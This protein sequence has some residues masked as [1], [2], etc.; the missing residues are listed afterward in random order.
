MQEVFLWTTCAFAFTEASN[1]RD[2]S[3]GEDLQIRASV[4][5]LS[6]LYS[7]YSRRD[8]KN[9]TK[10]TSA[11][12]CDRE[13]LK[14]AS[15]AHD[16]TTRQHIPPGAFQVGQLWSQELVE[17]RRKGGRMKRVITAITA[18]FLLAT[19]PTPAQG[20]ET[21]QAEVRTDVRSFHL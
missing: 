9:D 2:L 6:T 13:G 21:L 3:A 12:R 17:A 7:E 11:G 16:S 4:F 1:P 18:A 20:P 8:R 15:R 5:A 19:I 10:K 14:L